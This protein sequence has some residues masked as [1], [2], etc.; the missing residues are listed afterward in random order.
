LRL[1]GTSSSRSSSVGMQ[2]DRQVDLWQLLDHAVD[3]RHDS[4]RLTVMWRA[5]IPSRAGSFRRRTAAKTVGIVQRLA[6]PMK[7]ML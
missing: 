3:P 5:P 6:H 7:T 4:R 2:A 1:I